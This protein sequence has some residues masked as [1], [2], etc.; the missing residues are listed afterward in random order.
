MIL[1]LTINPALD[2]NVMVDRLA[3]EDRGYILSTGESQGGRGINASRVIQQF[4]GETLAIATTGGQTGKRFEQI[5]GS[6]CCSFPMELVRTESE[7]RTNLTITDKQG[8]TVKLNEIGPRLTTKELAK[9]A[10]KVE[11]RLD[12]AK[13]FMICGSLPPGVPAAFYK[14]LIETARR[15]KVKTLLDTD[16]DA[17]LHG[18]E[19]S[20]T[21]VSPNQ[22]ETERLLNRALI[23]RSHLIEAVQRLRG[24]GAES[25]VLSLGSR[26]AMA[27]HDSDIFEA[28]PPRID[29][30]SPIGAGD[31]LAAAFVWAMNGGKHFLDAVRWGVAAGTASAKLPG[32]SFADLEMTREVYSQVDVR[33]VT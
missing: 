23:T 29:A 4:G 6:G 18:M 12:K 7:M 21:V 30:I 20:P 28:I 8:L 5:S 15:R 22:P 26:G 32:I 3:F 31:A 14:E 19:A 16:G 1:T 25:V 9:I 11:E 13:W 33:F 2:R 17:L 24:M 10:S 27:Q